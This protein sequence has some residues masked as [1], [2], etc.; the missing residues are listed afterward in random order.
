MTEEAAISPKAW[1]QRACDK[2]GFVCDARQMAA[3]GELEALW[4][5]LMAFKQKRNQFLGRSLLSPEVPRGLYIWGGARQDLPDG[6]FLPLPAV[7]P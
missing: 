2:A 3:I 1:Y 4:Q 5:Q 7:P 6:R